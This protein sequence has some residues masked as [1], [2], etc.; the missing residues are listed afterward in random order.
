M[1]S[2]LEILSLSCW[3][4]TNQEYPGVAWMPVIERW[5][6]DSSNVASAQTA[7]NTVKIA[8]NGSVA[9]SIYSLLGFDDS[10]LSKSIPNV[11]SARSTFPTAN[12]ARTGVKAFP[13]WARWTNRSHVV[14][15]G[16]I[17]TFP[18]NVNSTKA[19]LHLSVEPGILWR[20]VDLYNYQDFSQ[21]TLNKDFYF[22]DSTIGPNTLSLLN[23][24]SFSRVETALNSMPPVKLAVRT[25]IVGSADASETSNVK[26]AWLNMSDNTWVVL[27][28]TTVEVSTCSSSNQ[29][30][31]TAYVNM[32]LFFDYA[33]NHPDP[34]APLPQH[35]NQY[36]ATDL[37]SKT[38]NPTTLSYYPKGFSSNFSTAA[39][40]GHSVYS[41]NQ[42]D[43]AEIGCI[44]CDKRLQGGR[45]CDGCG[46]RF[47]V[48]NYSGCYIADGN[49]GP[50][51][52]TWS[53]AS[54]GSKY[55]GRKVVGCDAR[56]IP[57]TVPTSSTGSCSPPGFLQK[58]VIQPGGGFRAFIDPDTF[59]VTVGA[60]LCVTPTP[61][62][63]LYPNQPIPDLQMSQGPGY[64]Q[65]CSDLMRFYY[66]AEPSKAILVS[67]PIQ[68]PAAN[69]VGN[70]V[71]SWYSVSSNQWNPVCTILP[72]SEYSIWLDIPVN[73]LTNPDFT[74]GAS[75][76]ADVTVTARSK[77]CDGFGARI[78]CLITTACNGFT[79]ACSSPGLCLQ[80]FSG[81]VQAFNGSVNVSI[82]GSFA[83]TTAIWVDSY[84]SVNSDSWSPQVT[85]VWDAAFLAASGLAAKST[86]A[87]YGTPAQVV[88][89]LFSAAPSNSLVVTINLRSVLTLQQTR[90]VKL[91]WYNRS[92]DA[93][94]WTPICN[95]TATSDGVVSATLDVGL[96]TSPNFGNWS[97]GFTCGDVTG[98]DGTIIQGPSQRACQKAALLVVVTTPWSFCHQGAEPNNTSP[99]MTQ[100]TT[101]L[102]QGPINCTKGTY[103]IS[104]PLPFTSLGQGAGCSEGYTGTPCTA[105][106][107]GTFKNIAGTSDCTPCGPDTYSSTLAATCNL[108]C[109][110]CPAFSTTNGAIG[111]SRCL[112]N[113]GFQPVQG[114]LSSSYLAVLSATLSLSAWTSQQPT[115]F[116]YSVCAPCKPGEYKQHLGYEDCKQCEVGKYQASWNATSCI[117]CPNMSSS[118]PGST[119]ASQCVCS[120]GYTLNGSSCVPC[121]PG[122]FK[123]A[124]GSSRCLFC[125]FGTYSSLAARASVAD[126]HPCKQVRRRLL[127][128]DMPSPSLT[129]WVQN[130]TTRNEGSSASIDC[131]CRPGYFNRS[132]TSDCVPC[133]AG[134][135]KENAGTGA[136]TLCAA[137]YYN[138]AA[139]TD[140]AGA[141]L[142]CPAGS[143][144]LAGSVSA[145][146]CIC[147]A[148]YGLSEY[149]MPCP[150]GQFSTASDLYCIN[151]TSNR[152][153]T[154]IGA[155]ASD[156][157]IPCPENSATKGSGSVQAS[158]CECAF[159]YS[160]LNGGNCSICQPGTYSDTTGPEPCTR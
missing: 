34:F 137:G 16:M 62:W 65:L 45:P 98:P 12:A 9:V 93:L 41:Q 142:P 47:E 56:I 86:A 33:R 97:S 156:T 154:A 114:N 57:A 70:K 52:E 116:R 119:D 143:S 61:N 75:G 39:D 117:L 49:G 111:Q 66:D 67:V 130:T 40:G 149:C 35:E 157:C 17:W 55:E 76:C 69:V 112:C 105:C 51:P 4:F 10:T 122:T 58:I 14:K 31:A 89:V 59:S 152:Y 160:G 128:S 101:P 2:C 146:A 74:N 15:L 144:S 54:S 158:Q 25:P 7:I 24:V 85:K 99:A 104:D 92:A 95:S 1:T 121:P 19:S 106:S 151:C 18:V 103:R 21:E 30:Q 108:T 141:C 138:P 120:P 113:A 73:V 5:F 27:C 107:A 126:C 94:F 136:C 133:A 37:W 91:A 83:G 155:M 81:T 148:G 29:L 36:K 28:N 53:V 8:S 131:V 64:P 68:Y 71:I 135:Y 129:L 80:S 153:S 150:P 48:F 87:M 125:D 26:L 20:Y 38:L 102:P 11:L 77:R 46:G 79:P 124:T 63:N 127:S 84:A 60:G 42:F 3:Q 145:S 82:S 6:L 109:L 140:F 50:R 159:G 96:L 110:Q 72:I 139:A 88:R 100:T 147:I 78:A 90:V 22:M 134:S 115:W 123:N 132:D 32:S 43:I 118:P 44:A 13:G 23:N